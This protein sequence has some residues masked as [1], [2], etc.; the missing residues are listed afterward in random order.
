MSYQDTNGIWTIGWG[1]TGREVSRGLIWAQ[2]QADQQF[3]DD[4]ANRAVSPV[5]NLVTVDVT[6]NQFAALCSFCFN[7]GQGNFRASSALHLLNNGQYDDVP[8]HIMLWDHNHDG[9]I[10]NGLKR[11][12]EAEVTLWG[13]E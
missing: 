13:K 7:I 12:R 1:H 3:L 9:S 10:S 5:N 4:L 8:S 6:D 2:E 11:R